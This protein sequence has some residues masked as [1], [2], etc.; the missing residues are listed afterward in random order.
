MNAADFAFLWLYL[1]TTYNY[2]IADFLPAG[3]FEAFDFFWSTR[4]N[5]FLY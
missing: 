2:N 4:D 5:T 3:L 1:V